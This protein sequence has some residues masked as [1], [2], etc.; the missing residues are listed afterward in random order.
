MR[1]GVIYGLVFAYALF[2]RPN[3]AVAIG[4]GLALGTSILI[5]AER[6]GFRRVAF[7]WLGMAAGTAA[8]AAPIVIYFAAHHALDWLWYGMFGVNFDYV[9]G[10]SALLLSFPVV[11]V[12]LLTCIAVLCTIAYSRGGWRM[13]LLVGC[14]MGLEFLLIGHKMFL[15]YYIVFFPFIVLGGSLASKVP[16]PLA[17]LG[18][19]V[20]LLSQPWDYGVIP[21]PLG[22]QARHKIL[23]VDIHEKHSDPNLDEGRRLV[24]SIPANERDQVWNDLDYLLFPIFTHCGI[25]QCNRPIFDFGDHNQVYRDHVEMQLQQADPLPTWVLSANSGQDPFLTA[26]D[27]PYRLVGRTEHYA[28]Y[29]LK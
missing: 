8:I 25:V 7:L 6:K 19:M 20:L 21:A 12:P 1:D 22:R 24:S 9:G 15:H 23:S 18:A 5:L 16:R 26:C 3:D 11:K 28:L 2:I 13:L 14:P 17:L 29:R 10:T 4:G 27:T